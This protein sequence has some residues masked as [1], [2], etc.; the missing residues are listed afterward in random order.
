[1]HWANLT[2][3]YTA[4]YWKG[5]H[6]RL[7]PSQRLPMLRPPIEVPGHASYPSGH[8][9][10]ATLIA[11]VTGVALGTKSANPAAQA[12]AKTLANS[13]NGLAA[14]IARNRELG[15]LHYPSDTDGGLKLATAVFNFIESD[16]T[17]P[18]GRALLSYAATMEAAQ[19]EW[20]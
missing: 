15:G 10:Q 12:K 1:M 6:K 7:R 11:L 8:S 14:R 5:V 17:K 13:L 20:A 4:M 2:A 19:G 3:A 16:R 18:A 9:T